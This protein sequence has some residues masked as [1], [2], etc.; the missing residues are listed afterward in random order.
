MRRE[1]IELKLMEIE[2]A[3]ELLKEGRKVYRVL[4]GLMIEIDL[5]EA[6]EYLDKLEASLKKRLKDF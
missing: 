5:E 2:R 1:D 6:K 4:G 3:R